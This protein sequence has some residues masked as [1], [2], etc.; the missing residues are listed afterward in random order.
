MK[1]TMTALFVITIVF[2]FAIGAAFAELQSL[3]ETFYGENAGHGYTS[4]PYYNTFIGTRAG[5]NNSTSTGT[6]NVFVGYYCGYYNTSGQQNVFIG[7]TAG[8]HNTSGSSNSFVGEGAG[9]TNDAGANNTFMGKQAG[10]NAEAD[11]NSFFGSS[12]GHTNTSGAQNSFF[13]SFSGHTNSTG[14]Y[15]TY[16]GFMA[17]YESTGDYNVFL[18]Y[19]AGYNET[20][21]NKLYISNYSTSSPLIY[22][23]FSD[24]KVQINGAFKVTGLFESSSEGIKFYDGSIQSKGLTGSTSNDGSLV[25]LGVGAGGANTGSSNTFIGQVAGNANSTGSNNNFIGSGSGGSN[26]TGSSNNFMGYQAGSSS[27]GWYNN[28]IGTQAGYGNQG[29]GNNNFIGYQAGYSNQTGSNNNFIGNQAGHSHTTGNDNTFIGYSA[30]YLNETGVRNVFLGH[31]AGYNEMGSDR[32][33]ISNS[34]TANPLIYG[35]FENSLVK[36]NGKLVFASDERLKKNIEP[37]KS[38]LYKVMHLKGVSYEWKET[39]NLGKGREIGLIAQ[40]VESILPE[41]VVTDSKGYKAMS[42]DKMV[43]VLVEAIKEQQQLIK[44]LEAKLNRLESKDLTAQK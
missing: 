44:K 35:E 40:D 16:I 11:D 18:G 29:G 9:Q 38:S 7:E 4:G 43:P 6:N 15:N 30:G 19:T 22:G 41:L 34:N 8:Y 31:N 33:Y 12:S 10:F 37:L 26:T 5:Y 42:Y 2:I 28:F 39:E 14:S 1:R 20:G 32:L 25:F 21:S 17:G 27:N 13:G 23:D 24:P 36:I 3:T